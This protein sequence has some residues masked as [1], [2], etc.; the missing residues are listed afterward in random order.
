MSDESRSEN[1]K[2]R[3]PK[4]TPEELEEYRA[5]KAFLAGYGELPPLSTQTYAGRDPLLEK[6]KEHHAD[7]A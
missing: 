5:R 4:L 3:Q 2:R 6:L 1:A 7:K